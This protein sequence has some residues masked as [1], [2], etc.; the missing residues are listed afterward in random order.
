M[1]WLRNKISKNF[2]RRFAFACH[3]GCL[4][5]KYALKAT[6]DNN[7]IH[8]VFFYQKFQV[9]LE[10]DFSQT[11][12][13]S[14]YFSSSAA[15]LW[16]KH[17]KV[18]TFWCLVEFQGNV[19]LNMWS[20]NNYFFNSPS[21]F[22]FNRVLVEGLAARGHNVTFV[23]PDVDK[24]G[25]PNVHYIHLEKTYAHFY[26]WD[27]LMK[28]VT[29]LTFQIFKWLGT[30]RPFGDVSWIGVSSGFLVLGFGEIPVRRNRFEWRIENHPQLS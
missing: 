15:A 3:S 17:F 30:H 14:I 19:H 13:W 22:I 21:H 24:K 11:A 29:F 5:F 23:S 16:F 8:N 6:R 27:I 4:M 2:R 25:T 7:L 12:S 26:K 10:L 28:L 9:S 1:C 18:P 20:Q